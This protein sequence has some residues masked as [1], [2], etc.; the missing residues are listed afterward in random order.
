MGLVNI[1]VTLSDEDKSKIDSNID[2][3][4]DKEKNAALSKILNNKLLERSISPLK[5]L[6]KIALMLL[7]LVKC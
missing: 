3:N 7:K 6:Q 4:N 1:L 2:Q 5:K